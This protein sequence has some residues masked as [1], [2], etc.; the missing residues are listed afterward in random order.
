MKRRVPTGAV[1]NRP[2]WVGNGH[3]SLARSGLLSCPVMI[4]RFA[5]YDIDQILDIERQSFP[6]SPY[7]WATFIHLRWLH[8]ETFL[9]FTEKD[10]NNEEKVLGYMIFSWDGHLISMAV[11]PRH[12]REG[13]GRKLLETAFGLLRSK[14]MRAEVRRS[15][16]GAQA[17]Y[18]RMGFRRVGTIPNYYGNEDAFI[19]EWT[20]P[21]V[22]VER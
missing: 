21:R 7:D 15:N 9:V 16:L 1:Q 22:S 12:R 18:E 19:M 4:R 20:D 3:R 13:I 8:P 10:A 5:Q 11:H 6:K 2:I 14:R 17:F